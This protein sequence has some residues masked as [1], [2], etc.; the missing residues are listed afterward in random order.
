MK[1]EECQIHIEE[2]FDGELKDG[3]SASVKAHIASC[4]ECAALQ[5]ELEGEQEIYLRYQRYLEVSPALWAGVQ[6]KIAQEKV[7]PASATIFDKIKA[8]LGSSLA[9]PRLS[10]AY[11]AALVLIAVGATVAVMSYINSRGNSTN[12]I[13]AIDKGQNQP[14]GNSTADPQPT[15]PEGNDKDQGN[16][17]KPETG[18]G[19]GNNESPIVAPAPPRRNIAPK[20]KAQPTP[21]QLV[22]EAEQKYIAAIALLTKD[23]KERRSQLDPTV[24]ARFDTA[25]AA[26]DRTIEETR[27]AARR[28][29]NDP[30]ALQYMLAAYAKK[31]E[32]LRDIADD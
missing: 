27:Q 25:L 5:G 11:T 20:P 12:G 4:R 24:A 31:V 30:A 17:D 3:L 29:P 22:R 7:E 2:F 15:M 8:W 13:V 19:S 1:C 32:V 28:N 26:I 10:F 23:V 18:E 6:A 14:P 9:A 21:E 16:T